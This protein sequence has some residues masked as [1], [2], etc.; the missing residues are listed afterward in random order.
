MAQTERAPKRRVF[1]MLPN[2]DENPHVLDEALTEALDGETLRAADWHTL[3]AS[4]ETRRARMEDDLAGAHD[5]E[6]DAIQ[7]RLDE[8]DVHIRALEEEARISRFVEDTVKFSYE[9]RR[10]SEG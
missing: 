10:L 3:A 7:K 2:P 5:Y 6:R 8:L 1:P 9:V 4:L